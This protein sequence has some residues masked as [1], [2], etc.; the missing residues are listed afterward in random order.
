MILMRNTRK[1]VALLLSYNFLLIG[2][3]LLHHIQQWETRHVHLPEL[4]APLLLVERSLVLSFAFV[5]GGLF[6]LIRFGSYFPFATT[7]YGQW[8]VQTGWGSNMPLPLGR[9]YIMWKDAVGL[10]LYL[11]IAGVGTQSLEIVN[12]LLVG[13]TC[14]YICYISG[15]VI[16]LGIRWPWQL[17]LFAMS[18]LLVSALWG[19]L[20]VG[21]AI[22]CL[23]LV[24]L[25]RAARQGIA[26]LAI[27]FESLWIVTEKPASPL[28][29]VLSPQNERDR[30]LLRQKARLLAFSNPVHEYPQL[31]NTLAVELIVASGWNM[32]ILNQLIAPYLEQQVH[33]LPVPFIMLGL[34]VIVVRSILY[35]CCGVPDYFSRFWHG[36]WFDW[37]TDRIWLSPVCILIVSG[38]GIY[39][40][41]KLDYQLLWPLWSVALMAAILLPGPSLEEW[42]L[43]TRINLFSQTK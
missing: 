40:D 34:F 30:K 8:L 7:L 14:S 37:Q 3:I 31:S 9:P 25:Q 15:N 18:P 1:N 4:R 12:C 10:G 19:R 23:W 21:I 17:L 39:L 24:L 2:L 28:L 6:L 36:P 20:I 38:A 16:D 42:N 32:V 26:Q 33:Q 27:Q 22:S 13:F 29:Q 5:A 41:A 11:L 43:A 35:F